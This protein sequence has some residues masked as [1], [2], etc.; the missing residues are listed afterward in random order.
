MKYAAQY[1]LSAVQLIQLYDGAVP[2]AVFLKNHF[3]QHKK[4][5]SKDRKFIA[6]L[7]YSYFRLGH[8]GKKFS[9]D[10]AIK[11]A[12]F[13]CNDAPEHWASLYEENWLANWSFNLTERISF[14]QS[15][16]PEFNSQLI[17][18]FNQVLSKD[19]DATAFSL[20]QLIQPD[21]FIR[22]RPEKTRKIIAE[23]VAAKMIFQQ[24]LPTALALPNGTKLDHL[25]AMDKEA[26]V[27]DLSSQKVGDF[28]EI[29]NGE[30]DREQGPITVWDCCA[31]SGGKSILAKDIL[32]NTLDPNKEVSDQYAA[33]V[34]TMKDGS[35]IVGRL[36]NEEEGKYFVSQNPFMPQSLREIAKVD[37]ASTKLSKVSLM[38]PG[39]L[40]RLNDEEIKDLVAYLVAGGNPDSEVYKGK[41][42]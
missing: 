37:V 14:I 26:I 25:I 9:T 31:A 10:Q 16:F 35:S 41:A 19:I 34:F 38:L 13:C 27:Q 12:V 39:L 28:F 32:E 22:L 20:A 11:I 3:S 30:W 36:I 23:L 15:I 6:Q 40:G 8:A 42:Q 5:G 4:Y 24:V 7:C 33:T 1:L 17:F 18:P 21:L 29:I 2:L